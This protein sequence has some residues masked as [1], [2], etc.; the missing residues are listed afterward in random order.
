[1][2]DPDASTDQGRTVLVSGDTIVS[3]SPAEDV[4]VPEGVRERLVGEVV[5]ANRR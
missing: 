2:L 4:E 5:A 3:L 1:V